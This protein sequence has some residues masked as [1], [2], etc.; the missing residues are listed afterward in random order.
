MNTSTI[1]PTPPV[2]DIPA[3]TAPP[4]PSI[5]SAVANPVLQI[6]DYVRQHPGT[7][8]LV[9]AGLG[10]AGILVMRALTPAP[11]RNRAV[12]LLE[13]IQHRLASLAQH[14]IDRASSLAAD[15]ANAASKGIDSLETFQ[16]G[17]HFDKISRGLKNLFQ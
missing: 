5:P 16:V 17:R 8:L 15:G 14:G 4:D 13:D 6:E 2:P 12:Q 9:A 3:P 7:A 11:P 1:I 10:L